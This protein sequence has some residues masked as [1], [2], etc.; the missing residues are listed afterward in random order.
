MSFL[1]KLSEIY[2]TEY[3]SIYDF[4][5]SSKEE[6][7]APHLKKE[8]TTDTKKED[9]IDETSITCA[10]SDVAVMTS[11]SSESLMTSCSSSYLKM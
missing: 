9:H 2:A 4:E 6:S 8:I 10:M 1:Q 7:S 5:S 3:V 11:A